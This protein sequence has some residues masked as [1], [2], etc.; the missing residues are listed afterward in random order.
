MNEFDIKA[1]DWDKNP[2]HWERSLSIAKE[3]KNHIQLK[4]KMKALEYG[5]GTGILSI[6]L[7]NDF[8]E[9]IL[10]DNSKEMLKI[11]EPKIEKSKVNN[12]KPVFFDLENEEYTVQKFDVIYTQMVIHH[13]IDTELIIK[14]FHNLLKPNGYLIIADLYKEDGT[15][16]DANFIGHNGF[17]IEKLSELIKNNGFENITHK[18]CFVIDKKISENE[19]KKFPVFIL[20]AN[21]INKS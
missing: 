8:D 12:I 14:R 4:P 21:P 7:K 18:Q 19:T 15:F 5:A 9:I 10:M 6:L 2:M 16:H 3:I 11:V 13:I 20:T 17:D 1:T